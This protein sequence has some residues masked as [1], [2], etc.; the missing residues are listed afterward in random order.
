MDASN[1]TNPF[2][3]ENTTE[4]TWTIYIY[5]NTGSSS[6]DMTWTITVEYSLDGTTWQTFGTT[7]ITRGSY[8]SQEFSSSQR[9]V[10]LRCNT[11]HWG[12]VDIDNDRFYMYNIRSNYDM[13]VG[14]NI[15][16]L[17]YGSDFVENG[18][19][20]KTFPDDTIVAIFNGL[21]TNRTELFDASELVLPVT[22]STSAIP[23]EFDNYKPLSRCY[24][25]MFQGCTN[26][27]NGPH[28]DLRSR[29]E[30]DLPYCFQSMFYGCTALKSVH[31]NTQPGNYRFDGMFNSSAGASGGIFYDYSG[32][33]NSEVPTA[34]WTYKHITSFYLPTYDRVVD[35]KTP[36]NENIDTV[37]DSNNVII[38]E[39]FQDKNVPFYV[40]NIT[41]SNETLSIKK[42]NSRAPT[43]SVQY[44][45]D[46]STW[47]TLNNTS[48]TARTVTVQP[49]EKIYLRC[50]A[51][52]W[53][54]TSTTSYRNSITGVSKVGGNIMSLLYG[55]NFT[56]DETSFPSTNAN[57]FACIFRENSNLLDASELLLPATTLANGCYC[58]MFSQDSLLVHG[59]KRLPAKTLTTE[60][61]RG[62]F[63]YCNALAECPDLPA[64]TLATTC[65]RGMFISCNALTTL[66]KL[67]ATTL[68]TGC[69]QIMFR[70]CTGIT[71]APDLNV[72]TL[73]ADCYRGMFDGCTSLNYVKCLAEN[74]ITPDGNVYIWLQDVAATGTFVKAAGSVWETGANGIPSGWTVVEE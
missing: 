8:I 47:K 68:S 19:V 17:L 14:G 9:R 39:Y 56:G 34:R 48:T 71:K 13:K 59:P 30:Y 21:F 10:Y 44:S 61:Y 35:W 62:M 31:C 32:G 27:V 65:Y 54:N 43:L 20:K 15:M 67:N 18:V 7:S 63:E 12:L 69:Y 46:R 38:Y 3:I 50:S 55:S 2:W 49:G 53:G 5:S 22:H 11:T 4:N 74:D 72:S 66:P 70:Y 29:G 37:T 45:R 28:I 25:A 1:Y 42:S 26:L 6:Y 64:T 16:S 51:N 23:S 24:R 36:E 40:Q 41:N 33:T 60:C 73:V 58:G 57:T 52:G